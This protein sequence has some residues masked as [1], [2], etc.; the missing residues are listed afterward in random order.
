M[1][2]LAI[3]VSNLL[4]TL[5]EE[6]YKSAINFIEYLSEKRKKEK[7]VQVKGLFDEFQDIL[8]GDKGWE[9]ED[10]MLRDMAE[11]RKSRRKGKTACRKASGFR[12]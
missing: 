12:A 3:K 1:A 11:F 2:P 6:D 8:N 9:N 4:D 5:E 10:A 7:A